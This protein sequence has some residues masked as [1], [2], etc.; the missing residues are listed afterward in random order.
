MVASRTLASRASPK[1]LTKLPEPRADSW[2]LPLLEF[3]IREHIEV[4]RESGKEEGSSTDV[5][6]WS[7]K[8]LLPEEVV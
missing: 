2:M 4:G 3:P 8:R 6:G 7:D 5:I 1:K